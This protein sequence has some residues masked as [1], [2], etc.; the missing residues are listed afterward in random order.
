MRLAGNGFAGRKRTRVGLQALQFI[1][2]VAQGLVIESGTDV[3]GVMQL[4]I[5]AVDAEQQRTDSR[6]AS[7]RVSVAAYDELLA[8]GAFELIQS[9]ERRSV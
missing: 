6:A 2:K 3:A 8:L 1:R 5:L 4:A 9:R 7:L